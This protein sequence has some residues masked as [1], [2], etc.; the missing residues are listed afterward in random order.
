M[1]PQPELATA[2]KLNE[3]RFHEAMRLTGATPPAAKQAILQSLA[4]L[5]T[6]LGVVLEQASRS[7]NRVRGSAATGDR[8]R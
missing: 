3:T 1:S 4:A 5:D 8:S 7:A 6:Q 2:V